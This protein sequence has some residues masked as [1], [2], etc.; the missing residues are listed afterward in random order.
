MPVA[1]LVLTIGLSSG[2]RF[3]VRYHM[4][5]AAMMGARA[6][7]LEMNRSGA[8]GG[9]SSQAVATAKR[10]LTAS[11]CEGAAVQAAA[12]GDAVEVAITCNLKDS[13][14]SLLTKFKLRSPTI[15]AQAAAPYLMPLRPR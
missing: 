3:M 11:E 5:N 14:N 4:G 6:G 9:A 8:A 2:V 13:I 10:Y 15:T 12:S 1:M 7:A